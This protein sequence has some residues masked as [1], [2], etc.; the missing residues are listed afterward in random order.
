MSTAISPFVGIGFDKYGKRPLL[1][2]IVTITMTVCLILT[3]IGFGSCPDENLPCPS[4]Y[5]MAGPIIFFGLSYVIYENAIY[6]CIPLVVKPTSIGTAFGVMTAMMNGGSAVVPT[7][8]SYIH[9]ETIH[10]AGGMKGFRYVSFYFIVSK[11]LSGP[12]SRSSD[13]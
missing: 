3:S 7:I 10:M 4:R 12:Y 11:W 8:G 13:S 6:T 5:I 9:D 2:V 1:I